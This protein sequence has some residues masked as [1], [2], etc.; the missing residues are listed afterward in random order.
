MNGW[1][2]IKRFYHYTKLIQIIFFIFFLILYFIFIK[3]YF[4]FNN[5][6]ILFDLSKQ[7]KSGFDS[8]LLGNYFSEYSCNCQ[9]IS[10]FNNTIYSNK[11]SG[12][13]INA[14]CKTIQRYTSKKMFNFFDKKLYS[15]FIRIDFLTY[16]KR[17]IRIKD[18]TYCK[19]EY[20]QCGY[21]DDENA[22]CVLPEENCPINDIIINNKTS[23]EDYKTIPL[24]EGKYYFHYTNTKRKNIIISDLFFRSISDSIDDQ[25]LNR[26]NKNTKSFSV[27]INEYNYDKKL[28]YEANDISVLYNEKGKNNIKFRIVKGI[29]NYIN[30]QNSQYIGNFYLKNSILFMIICELINFIFLH[31][32]DNFFPVTNSP[33]L[34]FKCNFTIPYFY[35]FVNF[36][37][38]FFYIYKWYGFCFCLLNSK[39]IFIIVIIGRSIS[40]CLFIYFTILFL[41]EILKLIIETSKQSIFLQ[42]YF[43][44]KNPSNNNENN[45]SEEQPNKIE[46]N[47][48]SNKI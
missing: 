35:A 8:L 29:K 1:K 19:Q 47:D 38:Q 10:E 16:L 45:I 34:L 32:I 37:I 25:I 3:K 13:E 14:G 26:Y 40:I 39:F 33:I 17:I 21:L 36:L 12:K 28:I 22:F 6:E 5:N 30:K 4:N 9:S 20:K 31:L 48:D 23:I 7:P 44:L 27:G 46:M 24:K 15:K 41:G 43:H 42:K 11:C 18:G 2:N